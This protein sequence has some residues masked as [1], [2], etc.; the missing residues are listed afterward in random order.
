MM[1]TMREN[2]KKI[3]WIVILAFLATI[4]F[5][6][7]KGGFDRNGRY[8]AGVLASVNGHKIFQDQFDRRVEQRVTQEREKNKGQELDENK[9]RS[10]RT[11]IWDQAVN[12]VLLSDELDRLGIKIGSR[13]IAYEIRNNP[14]EFVQ[15]AEYFKNNGQFDQ[16][17]YEDFLKNP[18]AVNEVIMLEQDTE[19]RLRQ[20]RLID[21]VTAAAVVSPRE[22]WDEFTDRN[23]TIKLKFVR[24]P[25]EVLPAD[26]TLVTQEEIEKDYKARSKEFEDPE[27]RKVWFVTFKE[28]PTAADSAHA[29]EMADEIYTRAKHGEDF[30]EL[31]R[32]YSEDNS[33]Q[34]GGSVGYFSRGRMVKSFE[35]TAFNTPIDSV[36]R[37]VLSQFGWHVIKVTGHKA[38]VAAKKGKKGQPDTPA[39]EEQVEAS[40]VLFKFAPSVETKDNIRERAKEFATRV[41]AKP[42]DVQAIAKEYNVKPDTSGFFKLE[43]GSIS[44][45]GRTVVGVGF[46]FDNKLHA[47]SFPYYIRNSWVILGVNEIKKSGLR[48]LAEVRRTIQDNLVREKKIDKALE[49][50]KGA[51]GM[52]VTLEQIAGAVGLKV[53]TTGMIRA[54]DY[55]PQLGREPDLTRTAKDAPLNTLLGPARGRSGAFLFTVVDRAKAD[56]TQFNSQ[57]TQ[58]MNQT[59]QR[60]QQQLYNDY[61]AKLKKNA[62]IQDFRY[63]MYSDF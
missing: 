2:T 25:V 59:M 44:K 5:A 38:T 33:A 4:I 14:P 36:A 28:V 3:L 41:Q 22:L 40:H 24:F 53:D 30:S 39:Q 60:R 11:E 12:E 42:N 21:Q 32:T 17:K 13:E 34:N 50:A 9:V 10:L 23:T 7:G 6:W 19:A 29:K 55:L 8:S 49:K 35:E 61:L 51:R 58:Q 54:N 45:L 15:Q 46:A 52:G 1:Q 57:M 27:Q 63:V 48:P 56:S 18:Q 26:T 62:K 47:I 20:Q 37:P 31:A 43:G 16:Q